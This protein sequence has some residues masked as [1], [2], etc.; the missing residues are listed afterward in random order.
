MG[1]FNYEKIG[2]TF[3][4]GLPNVEYLSHCILSFDNEYLIIENVN[5]KGILKRKVEVLN[6]FKIKHEKIISFDIIDKTNI[7]T[8][9]KSVLAR[10]LAGDILFGPVGALLGGLSGS[11]TDIKQKNE[12]FLNL[13]YYGKDK[14]D[15]K[16]IIFRM[17]TTDKFAREFIQRYNNNFL[18]LNTNENGEIIL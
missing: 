11:K 13:G 4:Q 3:L 10:G 16:T 18:T 8:K 12:Y 7:E 14:K 6:T 9:K 5:I 2:A 17:R 1:K 15:I